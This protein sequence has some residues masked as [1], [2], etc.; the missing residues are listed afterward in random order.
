MMSGSAPPTAER[1]QLLATPAVVAEVLTLNALTPEF[2]NEAYAPRTQLAFPLGG[3]HYINSDR[4]EVLLDLNNVALIPAGVT[5]R[6]RHPATGDMSCL[7]VTLDAAFL[8]AVSRG[9]SREAG[10]TGAPCSLRPAS[11]QVQYSAAVVAARSQ[12]VLGPELE[13]LEEALVTMVRAA[14]QV[15][16]TDE[17]IGARSMRLV[18]IVKELLDA[19][20]APLSLSAIAAEAGASPTYLTDLFRRAE[21]MPIYRY[22]NRLRLARSLL[23]LGDADDITD[24][25]LELGFSSHSHFTSTF[26]TTFGVTPSAHR[27]AV[28]RRFVRPKPLRQAVRAA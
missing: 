21:G 1:L 25:A 17:P 23:R 5:T 28:R 11:P 15:A 22:Q 8:E 13:G 18:R 7:V 9:R 24:L 4:R 26:R 27:E 16:A 20:T 19:T 3:L 10:L 6:D 2:T 14:S 12:A